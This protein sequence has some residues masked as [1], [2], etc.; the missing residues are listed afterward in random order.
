M[1][2][3]YALGLLLALCASSSVAAVNNPSVT[4]AIDVNANRHAIDPRIY[5]V[6]F[7]TP[8]DLRALNAPLNRSGG[9]TTST[10]NWLQNA[11]NHDFDYF[12]ESLPDDGSATA[13]QSADLFVSQTKSRNAQPMLTVP[14]IG[15]VAK[16]A[17]SRGK[18]AS[19][20]I[21][22][23]GPQCQFDPYDTDAGNGMMT[24]CATDITGNDPND[25]YVP[26]S[27]VN[28]QAWIQHLIATWGTSS[29]GGVNYYLMDNEPSIW[30]AT[31]RDVHP[32]GPHAAEIRDDVI[33]Y[34][35]MIKALDSNAQIAAPE[36]WGW[37]GYQYDGYDQQYAA[38]H[39]YCCYPDRSGVQGGLAYIPWLLQQWKAAGHPID[40]L[41][42]HFY[43]QGAE[44]SNDDSTATQ[45]LRNRSTRQ[46]WDPKYK[47]ESY[48]NAV[49]DLIP[50]LKGWVN[51]YYYPGTP[52]AVTEYNWGDEGHINGATTQADI[53]GIFGRQ[54]LDMATRWT[55]PASN[56]PTFKAMQMY[57]N[58]NGKDAGFGDTSV[59]AAAPNPD[60]LSAFGAQR[61][62][63][64][65]LTIMVINKIPSATPVTLTLGHFKTGGT[66]SAYQLTAANAIAHLA[67]VKWS[68]GKLTA[69]VPGQSIT[70]YVLPK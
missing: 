53:Y 29:A 25:A 62:A 26:D 58:Y 69:T 57:R 52:V 15:W 70:L 55:V 30:Y 49:V 44:Y 43:P 51:K 21:A 24:D 28:E 17:P 16:L 65:A 10:Y 34:S 14:M 6:S 2:S 13:G 19:F 42:V 46:L 59:K 60:Q 33:A 68:A 23:Y 61:T 12:F 67:S 45:L 5:G 50:V 38:A 63:D 32:D 27:V 20:S 37:Y 64:G 35:Q 56:T 36:E 54:A 1:M 3:K 40:I 7:G 47:S 8:A 18:A 22:K 4:V 41:S 9:N 31:H 11:S 66:A 48:I 39:G